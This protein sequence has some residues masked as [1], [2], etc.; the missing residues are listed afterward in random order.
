MDPREFQI[1]AQ[2]L[3]NGI[4]PA[5]IRTATSRAYYAVFNVCAA[6]LNE[7]VPLSRG[8]AGHGQVQRLL[9]NCGS[10]DLSRAGS[11]LSQ[12]HS[13][14]LDADYEMRNLTAENTKNAKAAVALAN[15]I[16]STVDSAFRG[17]D[18]KAI[19][20]RI[21]TYWVQTLGEP[22]RGRPSIT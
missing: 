6:G 9:L 4:S 2:R 18:A 12:L 5:E 8:A 14:R 10:P 7:I 20:K 15:F 17:S 1:L 13:Q 11:N 19:K 3:S 22:L 21:Q 16:I